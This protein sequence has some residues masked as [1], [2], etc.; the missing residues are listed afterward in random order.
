MFLT[1]KNP[2]I[3]YS[4]FYAD[5]DPSSVEEV[6]V[7]WVDEDSHLHNPYGPAHVSVSTKGL[8]IRY[9]SNRKESSR[10][11]LKHQ[12]EVTH[13]D[14]VDDDHFHK[15]G[16]AM[17]LADSARDHDDNKPFWT[18]WIKNFEEEHHV[19]DVILPALFDK[20]S[21]EEEEKEAEDTCSKPI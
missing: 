13:L 21:G 2:N 5:N 4:L 18:N 10:H 6:I 17:L 15:G 20:I 14:V 16:K 8:H 7:E 9:F 3:I 19:M 12:Y 1:Y 11:Y